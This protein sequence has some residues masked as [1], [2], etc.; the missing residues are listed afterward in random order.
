MKNIDA[1]TDNCKIIIA[2][3]FLHSDLVYR[4][5]NFEF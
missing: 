1:R 4:V 2:G 5:L 3:L